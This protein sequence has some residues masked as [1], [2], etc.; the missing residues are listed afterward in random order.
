MRDSPRGGEACLCGPA[1]FEAAACAP[2]SR[3]ALTSPAPPSARRRPSPPATPASRGRRRRPAPSGRPRSARCGPVP[4]RRSP[5][6]VLSASGSAPPATT[7]SPA[8]RRRPGSGPASQTGYRPRRHPVEPLISH[9]LVSFTLKAA[10]YPT[11]SSSAW[12]VNQPAA[13]P[14][15]SACGG[16]R[17]DVERWRGGLPPPRLAHRRRWPSH[18]AAAS[19]RGRRH[20]P[21]TPTPSSR[22]GLSVPTL[23]SGEP[24]RAPANLRNQAES[25]G[26]PASTLP[27]AP[28]RS[29]PRSSAVLVEPRW[30]TPP[31]RHPSNRRAPTTIPCC[32]QVRPQQP[33]RT[34]L[35]CTARC[36]TSVPAA[37]DASQP[38]TVASVQRPAS[39]RARVHDKKVRLLPYGGIERALTGRFLGVG[40]L[41]PCPRH[42]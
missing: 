36:T 21:R 12:S 30:Q 25:G 23:S 11:Q 10:D 2:S 19:L 27:V 18:R 15:P 40:G 26:I 8:T 7:T 4:T 22:V 29:A 13:R 5:T 6:P 3:C 39:T 28:E 14:R 37:T 34:Y 32:R 20:R 16:V 42:S 1:A 38:R 33:A 31:S 35:S 24:A 9:E 17:T 41:R